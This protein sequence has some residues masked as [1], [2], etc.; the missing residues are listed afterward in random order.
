MSILLWI[1]QFLL[2]VV[3]LLAGA[4]KAFQ[5]YDTLAHRMPWVEEYS[6]NMV[7]IIGAL[8]ILGA[9]GLI[10][11]GLLGTLP[12]LTP[13]AAVGL[14]VLMALA[15]LRHMGRHEP[16]QMRFTALLLVLLLVVALGR[17]LL[18]PL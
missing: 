18:A 5:P 7:R 2:A 17:F 4:V 1:L 10:L 15:F 16:G 12:I 11:P 9:L 3:F 14:A 8:E 6:P 13:V